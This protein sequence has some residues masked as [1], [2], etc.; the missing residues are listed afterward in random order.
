MTNTFSKIVI[1]FSAL[2]F[3]ISGCARN[4]NS[5]EYTSLATSGKVLEG[6]IVSARAV[7]VNDNDKLENNTIGMLGGGVLGGVAGS[8]IGKGQGQALAAVGGALAGAVAGSVAQSKL[9][10]SQGTEYIIRLDPKYVT[11]SSAINKKSVTVGR[12]SVDNQ[13]SDSVGVA[14][15]QT[16][17]LSVVQG[18]D[19]IMQP[20][21]RVLIIY[22]NDRPRVTP[23]Y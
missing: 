7:T 19:I 4:L 22:N 15:T 20:G 9:G 2:S 21:Q 10:K 23:A 1:T 11:T 6:K 8:V 18:N 12:N 3:I 13:I 17:L 16:D 14:N 5:G